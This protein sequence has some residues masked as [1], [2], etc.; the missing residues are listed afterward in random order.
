MSGA[1]N[2]SGDLAANTTIWMQTGLTVNT[3][4]GPFFVQVFNSSGTANSATASRFTLANVPSAL[5]FT[6]VQSSSVSVSWSA[7]GNPGGTNYVLQRSTG[8]AFTTLSNST[9][10]VYVDTSVAASS[11]YQ[12]Q[13]GATNGDAVA[14]AFTGSI[15]TTTPA[16]LTAPAT[17]T[18]FAGL[19]VSS[20]SVQWSWTDNA[21]N[22]TGYRVMSGAS[23]ISGNLAANTTIWLQTG[24]TANTPAGPYKAE[25]FN[26]AGTSDSSAGSTYTLAVRP[27][28]SAAYAIFAS[29]AGINWSMGVNPATTTAEVQRS[30]DSAT[31]S[32]V[33]LAPATA[34]TDTSLLGC[35]SYYYRVR[36]F[37]V[38]AVATS[39]DS[40]VQIFT[41]NTIPH[42]AGGL[43]AAAIA[44]NRITLS[45]TPSYTEGITG[46]RL[47]YDN[48]SGIINYAAPLAVFASTESS[49]TTGP[50][51]SSAAY[52]FALRAD[53]RCGTEETAGVFASAPS[54]G[55]LA[56]VRAVVSAPGPGRHISG[57]A[58]MVA[59]S[60]IAGT[61]D[62][63]S[64]I[65]FQFRATSG[66]WANIPAVGANHPNPSQSA[67]YYVQW[68]VTGLAPGGYD[69]RAVA[70]NVAGS[71]DS[72]PGSVNVV[73]D[74]ITPDIT[75]TIVG[76]QVQT[77]QTV[78]TAV[79]NTIAAAGT[80]ATDPSVSII[81]PPGA[82]TGSTVT[83][84]VVVN[85]TV[86]TAPPTGE[87]SVGSTLQIDLSN[88]QHQLAGGQVAMITMSYPDG[89]F[90]PTTLQIYSLDPVAGVWT[91]DFAS[92]VNTA[93][94]TV[95]G[96]T[97]HFSVFT[98][99]SG[100]SAAPDL[101][102]VRAYPVPFKP[103]GTNPDE[104]RAF[105]SGDPNSGI[106]FDNLPSV[107]TIKIYTMTGRLV[108]KLDS[109]SGSGKLQWDAKNSDG[110]DVVSGGYIAVISSPGFKSVDKKLAI[111]R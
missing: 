108:V 20:S 86:M 96:M 59:A 61:Y 16:S 30:S 24:L 12:Y 84:T 5:A 41:A 40:T 100:V 89:V 50:L 48:G 67:P 56:N 83:A 49:F 42:S 94:R 66:T 46:Y 69:L 104:G 101:S 99:F 21:N 7:S 78:N 77:K 58:V 17:P 22:E 111:I 4:T 44:N 27:T 95:S 31:F 92:T 57:N 75:Q 28:A 25:A 82:L 105:S 103:N 68:D 34:Y 55:T 62:Q 72:A 81:V 26:G 110:R 29:S 37:N 36:A 70:V 54:T 3:S 63:V 109:N 13:V 85:P 15:S 9:T 32:Q 35:T 6:S 14:T 60:V 106:I 8:G 52:V 10:T 33:L 80:G 43:T 45:W 2:I 23:N 97:P 93:S 38:A 39:F 73:V 71:S 18:G 11:P 98:L 53:H 87:T 47:F 90:D 91:K 51:I 74:P 76:S 65:S 64:Q 19:A 79:V 102:S 1:A 107:F 88:G